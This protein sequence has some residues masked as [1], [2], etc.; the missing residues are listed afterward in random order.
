VLTDVLDDPM[1]Y[2]FTEKDVVLE[3]GRIWEDDLHLTT[4]VQKVFAEQFV[5]AMV[6]NS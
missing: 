2:K 5:N 4:G 6:S 1:K 3:G